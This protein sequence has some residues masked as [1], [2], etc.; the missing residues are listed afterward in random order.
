MGMGDI[1]YLEVVSF[2]NGIFC[3]NTFHF[4][5]NFPTGDSKWLVEYFNGNFL[6]N[7]LPLISFSTTFS[8]IRA[9]MV[10]QPLEDNYFIELQGVTG[11]HTALTIDPRLCVMWSLKGDHAP[12]RHSQGRLFLSGVPSDFAQEPPKIIDA[13]LSGHNTV[14]S[15]LLSSFGKNG[16]NPFLKWGVFSKWIFKLGGR[17]EIEYWYPIEKIYQRPL[18]SSLKTRR[19]KPPF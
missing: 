16:I 5:V 7:L 4:K 14:S 15:I 1:Y 18:L 2:T 8:A 19:Q 13:A 3:R 17:S 9:T 11:T 12:S 6:P 10:S